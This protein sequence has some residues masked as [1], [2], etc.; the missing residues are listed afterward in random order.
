MVTRE[1]VGYGGVDITRR[2]R[3]GAE[4]HGEGDARRRDVGTNDARHAGGAGRAVGGRVRRRRQHA[5]SRAS[6]RRRGRPRRADVRD[7][8]RHISPPRCEQRRGG[9]A[10]R[11]SSARAEACAKPLLV[12]ENARRALGDAAGGVAA[13]AAARALPPPERRRSSRTR[14][15][16]ADVYVGAHAY[17]GSGARDRPRRASSARAPTSARD[18]R[19][20]GGLAASAGGRAWRAA[21]LGDRV[22]LHAGLRD[23]QRRLRLGVRG[24]PRSSAFRKSATWCLEDDVEIGANT[25]VDRAQTGSTRIGAGTKIDNLVQI[26]HNC[27]IGKHCVIAALTGLA[28][29]TTIGDYVKVGGQVGFKGH[30]TIGSGVTI[31]GQS[32]VWRD[33]ADGATISGNP[34][35]DHRDELR[36][37]V[38]IRKLPKLFDRVEA[39]ERAA[40]APAVTPVKCKRRFAS[41]SFRGRRPPYRARVPHGACARRAPRCGFAFVPERRAFPRSREYVVDTSRATVLG[42]DGVSVSTDR[43]PAL[44]ALRRWASATPRSCVDGPEIPVCDG[45]AGTVRRG[46]RRERHRKRSV[47]RAPSSSSTNRF[48][49]AAATKLIAAFPSPA[50]RVRFIADFPA[51]IGTQYF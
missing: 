37:E 22:V 44:G 30:I 5:R 23:R 34:A 26:G 6:R 36:R 2:R 43:A 10:R 27:R 41:A 48:R 32:G 15:L 46:D 1:G 25:C 20:R 24:R 11:R 39:L 42:R 51:P 19:R 28:G 35:R 40:L 3:K 8:A 14:E 9:G 16:A 4:H 17:V 13:A 47:A 12:V 49:C 21:S 29:S 45:S 33:V 50:F 7:D 38:M 18:D 31:A